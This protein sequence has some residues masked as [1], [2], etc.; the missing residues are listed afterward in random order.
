MESGGESTAFIMHC[1]PY[2]V[3]FKWTL[4]FVSWPL[5]V[6]YTFEESLFWVVFRNGMNFRDRSLFSSTVNWSTLLSQLSSCTVAKDHPV[7]LVECIVNNSLC[8]L[9]LQIYS[10]P[11]SNN[12]ILS[13]QW[14]SCCSSSRHNSGPLYFIH[15]SL[16][17]KDPSK[18]LM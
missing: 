8:C 6:H 14:L 17:Q 11:S 10:L 9:P 5:A 2:W 4:S 12:I 3:I 16:C 15:S 7:Y 18:L 13:N 1:F